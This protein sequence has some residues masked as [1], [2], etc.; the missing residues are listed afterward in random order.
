MTW[1]MAEFLRRYLLH[2]PA[3]GTRVVRSYGL[4]APT[5]RAALAVFRD[6]LGQGPVEA[7]VVL[8]W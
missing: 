5:K 6:Q 1:P 2:V 8:D 7:P 3:P 4:D